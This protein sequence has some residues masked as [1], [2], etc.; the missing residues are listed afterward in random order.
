MVRKLSTSLSYEKFQVL[1][2]EYEDES[3]L[4]YS[5]MARL[6]AAIF[7]QALIFEFFIP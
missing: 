2:S 3:L 1:S 7:Q 6:L 5:Y 4:G